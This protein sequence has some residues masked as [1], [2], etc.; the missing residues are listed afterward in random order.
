MPCCSPGVS[1]I[2]DNLAQEEVIVAR[3]EEKLKLGKGVAFVKSRLKRLRQED[4]TWEADFRALPKPMMQR[5]T[6]Y[7]GLVVKKRGSSRRCSKPPMSAS[8]GSS[9][10]VTPR[11]RHSGTTKL[12]MNGSSY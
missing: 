8:S 7:L 2:Q 12:S 4:E 11:P 5:E 1:S 10:R 9:P 3:E 6:H